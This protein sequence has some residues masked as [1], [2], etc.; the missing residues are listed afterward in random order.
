MAVSKTPCPRCTMWSSMGITIALASVVMAPM[1]LEY[2]AHRCRV[3]RDE[4]LAA[5]ILA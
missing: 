2:I 5:S 1:A 4:A 3:A